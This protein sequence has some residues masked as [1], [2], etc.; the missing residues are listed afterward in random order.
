MLSILPFQMLS[1]MNKV[2]PKKTLFTQ[3]SFDGASNVQKAGNIM[4]KHYDRAI[5]TH[6]AEH[7]VSLVVEKLACEDIFQHFSIFCKVVSN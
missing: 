5:V 3:V 6:G 7:V 4:V 1:I 2:D